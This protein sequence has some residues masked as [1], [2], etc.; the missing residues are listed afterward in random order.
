MHTLT[1]IKKRKTIHCLWLGLLFGLLISAC[2]PD[3]QANKIA[4]NPRAVLD[5]AKQT[6]AIVD[7]QAANQQKEIDAATK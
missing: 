4:E 7:E 1:S 2:S 3:P 6:S 5:Q